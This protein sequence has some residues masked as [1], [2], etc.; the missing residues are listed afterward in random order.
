MN[1][2]KVKICGLREPRHV[3]AALR[4]GADFIGF[5]IFPNSPRHIEPIEARPLSMMATGIA[6]TVA[7]VVDPDDALLTQVLTD[8]K[9]DYI[10]LH[11]KETPQ[12]CAKVRALGVGVIKA[13]G[14]SSRDDLEGVAAYERHVD[15]VLFDAKPPKGASRTGGL[16]HTF[17]WRILKDLNISTPWMLSGGLTLAN[18]REAITITGA[19]MLDLSSG[20]ET[21]P[22]LKDEALIGAFLDAIKTDI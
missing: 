6:K 18:A 20:V 10:Q 5:I 16:G 22:G 7:V 11:G 14:V 12:F 19:K 4:H 8:L 3:A 21:A 13:I 17:D 2:T 1:P 15:I 9:P